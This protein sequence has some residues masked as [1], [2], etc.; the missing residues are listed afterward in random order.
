MDTLPPSFIIAAFTGGLTGAVVTSLFNL[1]I[2][3]SRQK[4]DEQQYLI[5][6]GR[7]L[8]KEL[9]ALAAR[10]NQMDTT[11]TEAKTLPI[12]I[13]VHIDLIAQFI[14]DNLTQDADIQQAIKSVMTL[15]KD[16]FA[17]TTRSAD[18]EW[19]AKSIHTITQL[20]L[21]LL[22]AKLKKHKPTIMRWF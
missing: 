19:T 9:M 10:Y 21:S 12:E 2:M 4:W 3:K 11:S 15:T 14:N 22:N 6:L 18:T 7:E 8:C 20:H 5:K 16:D 1:Y 17:T 13:V